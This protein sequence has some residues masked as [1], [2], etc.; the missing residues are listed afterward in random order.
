L[1]IFDCVWFSQS[2]LPYFPNQFTTVDLPWIP[3]FY[4]AP[5]VDCSPRSISV[6]T[7][8]LEKPL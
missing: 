7:W 4:F 2:K 3:F 1:G 6:T 8:I 5:V